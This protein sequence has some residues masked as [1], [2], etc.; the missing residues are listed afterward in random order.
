MAI[1]ITAEELQNLR[2]KTEAF[3]YYDCPMV[4][5]KGGC[6]CM[7]NKKIKIKPVHTMH[8]YITQSSAF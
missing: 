4:F 7:I 6:H 8:N 1:N 3:F 5:Y 2:N